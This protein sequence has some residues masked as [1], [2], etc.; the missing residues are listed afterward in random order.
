VI[1]Q[2]DF[3]IGG[4][5]ASGELVEILPD[6]RVGELGVYAIYA[7]RRHLPLKLRYLIDFLADSFRP[8]P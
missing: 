5:L 2:P 6:Y 1:L 7:S 3:L 4:D 8:A